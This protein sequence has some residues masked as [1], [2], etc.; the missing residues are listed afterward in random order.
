MVQFDMK[1]RGPIRATIT[2]IVM[3]SLFIVMAQS[4]SNNR[5]PVE[6]FG[7]AMK[8]CENSCIASGNKMKKYT[9]TPVG[10]GALD[11]S[12]ECGE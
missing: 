1:D 6:E 11:V 7:L 5:P 8:K 12:C 3:I 4:C 10:N 2:G 9:S